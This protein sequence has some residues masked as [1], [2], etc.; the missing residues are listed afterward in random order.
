[1]FPP[2][3]HKKENTVIKDQ[4]KS[5]EESENNNFAY[6]EADTNLTRPTLT[7]IELRKWEDRLRKREDNLNQREAD[8]FDVS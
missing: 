7:E 6:I 2:A 4:L 5:N 8:L 3:V 1:M